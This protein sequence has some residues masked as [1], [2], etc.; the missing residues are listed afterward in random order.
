MDQTNE[1]ANLVE[2]STR[3]WS[4]SGRGVEVME[5]VPPFTS[6]LRRRVRWA[7]RQL[8]RGA[9]ASGPTGAGRPVGPAKS[10]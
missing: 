4:E 1:R 5:P 6:L 7:A 3:G 8:R 10:R 2:R 9:R